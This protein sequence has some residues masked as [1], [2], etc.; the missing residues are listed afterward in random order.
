LESPVISFTF[1][2]FPRS[3]L[4]NGGA[5]LSQYG[6]SGTY[7][8]CFGLM[9]Q[10]NSTGEIFQGEDLQKLIRE[11]HE[12]GC[13]TFDH[14]DSWKTTP[15]E[16]EASILK[17]RRAAAQHVPTVTLKSFSY[18]ITWPRPATKR[19][20]ASF[21]ECARGGGQTFNIGVVDLNYLKAFF[22]EQS[23]DD[24]DAIRQIIDD[25]TQAV[26]WLI[27]ATHDVSDSPTRFGC[28]PALFEQIV[29]YADKSGAHVLPVRDV[30]E[31][32]T[33]AMGS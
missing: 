26:G 12:L 18:P 10:Q 8:A 13:H 31:R 25:N 15:A 1:D 27:F 9:G 17:N 19:R 33:H 5:I 6:F 20:I 14:C 23:R 4:T 7:Y 11:G 2:D 29:D 28:A 3:A 21:F 24:F 16:F 30:S 32:V 22:I